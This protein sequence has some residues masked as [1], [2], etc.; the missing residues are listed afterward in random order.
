MK[1][2]TYVKMTGYFKNHPS[3]K[4]CLKILNKLCTL[5]VVVAYPLLLFYLF[6]L[7]TPELATA[8]IIPMNAFI[9]LT[10]FR[11]LINRQRPYEKFQTP[12]A[13]PKDKKGNSF[14]S[15][16][17]FSAFMIAFTLC[18]YGPWLWIGIVLLVV[19]T[20]IAVI[21]VVAGIHF[22]SDVLAGFGVAAVASIFYLI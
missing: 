13:I 15:R 12:P 4:N 22:I 16:H 7:K 14:P 11:F 6:T 21:R 1:K 10:V 9:I 5:I 2:D 18:V 3:Q 19:A 8:I 17:V 20:L